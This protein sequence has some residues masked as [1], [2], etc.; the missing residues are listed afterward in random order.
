MLDH[1]AIER[2]ANALQKRMNDRIEAHLPR[3]LAEAEAI[4]YE[5]AGAAWEVRVMEVVGQ[6]QFRAVVL[7]YDP[8]R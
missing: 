5:V 8:H 6:R 2:E 3:T 4:A 1:A 7:C